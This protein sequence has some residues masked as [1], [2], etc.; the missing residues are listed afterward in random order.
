M[1][2]EKLSFKCE[3][4]FGKNWKYIFWGIVVILLLF[5]WEINQISNRMQ[6]LE[7]V[8]YEITA[9][10]FLQLLTEEQ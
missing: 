5:L 1:Q 8:V 6:D 3:M 4:F 2:E 7:K 9:R 10:L